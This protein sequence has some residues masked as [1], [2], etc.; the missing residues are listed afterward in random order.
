M[1]VYGEMMGL[2]VKWLVD[3]FENSVLGIVFDIVV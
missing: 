1:G 3:Y 2:V